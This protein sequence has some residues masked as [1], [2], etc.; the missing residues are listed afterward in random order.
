MAEG[1]A[2]I[3][4]IRQGNQ[5]HNCAKWVT[6]G[7]ELNA[8]EADNRTILLLSLLTCRRMNYSI[9]QI[10][11]IV[12][13]WWMP[14]EPFRFICMNHGQWT[15]NTGQWLEV[16]QL[17][18]WL[19]VSVSGKGQ[20]WKS[21]KEPTHARPACA[22]TDHALHARHATWRTRGTNEIDLNTRLLDLFYQFFLAPPL[23]SIEIQ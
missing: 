10:E 21:N 23:A 4:G 11:K 8:D 12:L 22:T 19:Y 9:S 2:L 20:K 15:E 1:T 7:S 14:M 16:F 18:V 6:V 13:D 5:R 3:D 17:A